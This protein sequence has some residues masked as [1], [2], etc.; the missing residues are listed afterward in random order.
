MGHFTIIFLVHVY[1]AKIYIANLTIIKYKK[2]QKRKKNYYLNS[3]L[4][5]QHRAFLLWNI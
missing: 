2:I 3:K 4:E 1:K 5:T